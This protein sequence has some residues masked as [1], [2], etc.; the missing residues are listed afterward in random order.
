MNQEAKP[1]QLARDIRSS[2][3]GVVMAEPGNASRNYWLRPV[4]GGREWEV[5]RQYV[6][7][8]GS[9]PEGGTQ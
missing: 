8:L 4:G 1:R 5:P 6:Q 9:M 2:R 7:L 3:E